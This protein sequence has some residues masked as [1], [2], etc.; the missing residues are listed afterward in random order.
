MSVPLKYTWREA[1]STNRN[2]FL[3]DQM[4]QRRAAQLMAF[5]DGTPFFC[6]PIVTN[7]TVH[8]RLTFKSP[9]DLKRAA[10]M[11]TPA[12][13]Q[14]RVFEVCERLH[15]RTDES[16]VDLRV[17]LCVENTVLDPHN[18]V[19]EIGCALSKLKCAKNGQKLLHAIMSCTG[20]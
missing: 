5:D 19:A 8:L 10:P 20:C 12:F 6:T 18:A 17:H 1:V 4:Q 14:N 9:C 15:G 3:Q 7:S 16:D 2:R 11:I 13:S